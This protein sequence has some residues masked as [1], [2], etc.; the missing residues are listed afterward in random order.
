MRAEDELVAIGWQPAEPIARSQ[1]A[2]AH[3]FGGPATI[4]GEDD[5]GRRW[6]VRDVAQHSETITARRP[7][8]RVDLQDLLRDRGEPRPVRVDDHQPLRRGPRLFA[9]EGDPRAIPR[10]CGPAVDGGS[11]RDGGRSAA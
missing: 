1:L 5:D 4:R 9:Y 7:V 10:E 6:A 8:E 11:V 2:D 3:R